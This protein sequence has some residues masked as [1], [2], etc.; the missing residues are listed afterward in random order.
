M[1]HITDHIVLGDAAPQLTITVLDEPGPGGANHHY[2]I[3]TPQDPQGL[4]SG[5]EIGFQNGPIQ[6]AGING[7]TNEALLAVVIDCLKAFQAGPFSSEYNAHALH[8]TEQALS[9]L[10]MR[11]RDRIVRGVE[12]RSQA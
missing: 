1:R 12:G 7:I 10:Q 4:E 8:Y 11:T 2:L 5:C 6:E 3:A 9:A